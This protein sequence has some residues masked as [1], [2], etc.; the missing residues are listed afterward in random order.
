MKS[1]LIMLCGCSS[2]LLSNAL[3]YCSSSPA[4]IATLS[5][6]FTYFDEHLKGY[7]HFLASAPPTPSSLD[8]VACVVEDLCGSFSEKLSTLTHDTQNQLSQFSPGLTTSAEEGVIQAVGLAIGFSALN[9]ASCTVENDDTSE[10]GPRYDQGEGGQYRKRLR[11][12]LRS[13]SR[14]W[15]RLLVAL[16]DSY[17][18]SL[19]AFLAGD[20]R[21]WSPAEAIM[22]AVSAILKDLHPESLLELLNLA[23]HTRVMAT[24]PLARFA[25]LIAGESV[26][27]LV[28][29][30]LPG[31]EGLGRGRAI[32]AAFGAVAR[33]LLYTEEA[34]A[35]LHGFSAEQEQGARL[36]F[37]LKEDH[38]GI[39]SLG[40]LLGCLPVEILG[41]DEGD[42][43]SKRRMAWAL[44][45][46]VSAVAGPGR[47]SDLGVLPEG[48][49]DTAHP[50]AIVTMVMGA[51]WALLRDCL[52]TSPCFVGT[53]FKSF[54]EATEGMVGALAGGLRE[55][56]L[57][58]PFLAALMR[59]DQPALAA[60]ASCY[61]M[62]CS[63]L[64]Q[65]SVALEKLSLVQLAAVLT[66]CVDACT[67]AWRRGV[68]VVS[69]EYRAQMAEKRLLPALRYILPNSVTSLSPLALE[70]GCRFLLRVARLLQ[71]AQATSERSRALPLLREIATLA[72]SLGGSAS[73][74]TSAGRVPGGPGA[75]LETCILLLTIWR[76]YAS[77]LNDTGPSPEDILLLRRVIPAACGF[78]LEGLGA[79]AG[80]AESALFVT[81]TPLNK[82]LFS[83]L[84]ALLGLQQ[85]LHWAALELVEQG[86]KELE[87]SKA[88]TFEELR[89]T[90]ANLKA[91]SLGDEGIMFDKE[92]RNAVTR[93]LLVAMAVKACAAD[94]ELALKALRAQFRLFGSVGTM[95][96]L[97][98][99][100]HAEPKVIAVSN[101][102]L[103]VFEDLATAAERDDWKKF[104]SVARQLAK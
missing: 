87:V 86:E 53:T 57:L 22:H 52:G 58:V 50:G 17:K 64:C 89:Q 74:L 2:S 26:P 68:G 88:T 45:S 19:T 13:V 12:A 31:A 15:G 38:I 99:A 67:R 20:G 41:H 75:P 36:A 1:V 101:K 73:T 70:S 44:E 63:I 65:V 98:E 49:G 81:R 11:G 14:V 43:N 59:A 93:T 25:V 69:M 72:L 48:E 78:L 66:S 47:S 42:E 51:Y 8:L 76:D 94:R 39:V 56:Y 85:A 77:F 29:T 4:D 92:A 102:A 32:N 24:R 79:G 37:R 90:W 46:V 97:Y 96:M 60:L 6:V 23:T 16:V 40:R 82:P 5:R 80:S 3:K 84:L 55:G 62:D 54:L 104:K 21:L 100:L 103:K 28:R 9:Q 71:A 61:D 33:S 95:A 83:L 18:S 27:V 34:P 30:E 35:R 91:N 10:I 7:L